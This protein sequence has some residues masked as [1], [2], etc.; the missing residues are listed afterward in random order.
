MDEKTYD[1]FW[2]EYSTNV[3][4]GVMEDPVSTENI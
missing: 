4:L 2:K 3:K 1:D